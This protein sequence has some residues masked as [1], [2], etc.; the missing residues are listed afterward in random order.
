M[1][2]RQTTWP[3]RLNHLSTH[4]GSS[5]TDR[6]AT[7]FVLWPSPSCRAPKVLS[8]AVNIGHP[9]THRSLLP[10]QTL[11]LFRKEVWF[12]PSVIN[13]LFGVRAISKREVMN[14][15]PLGLPVISRTNAGY[16][17]TGHFRNNHVVSAARNNHALSY[18]DDLNPETF[19]S[20]LI[21]EVVWSL[22]SLFTFLCEQPSQLKYIEW[23]SFQ[24]TLRTATL[25][26]ILV[27]L[28]IVA[29]SSVDS[30]LYCMLNWFLRRS[31]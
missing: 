7:T 21:K 29:L 22:K 24:S 16:L 18:D 2:P 6:F 13:F 10:P 17:D 11:P 31:S 1:L 5:P 14:A 23:P 3:K 9:L 8:F 25:T 4:L 26:L 19:W 30:A 12:I 27:A 20:S 15:K 28:L